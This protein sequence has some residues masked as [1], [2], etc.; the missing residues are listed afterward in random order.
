M[1]QKVDE[2]EHS[3][4]MHIPYIKKMFENHEFK[5]VPIM[6]GSIEADK[7]QEYGKK[8]AKYLDDEKTLFVISSDF[9]HWG[10][11]FDYY[12]YDKEKGEVYQSIE[13]MDRRGM[14]LIEK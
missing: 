12:P 11:N 14:D 7:E 1:N 10:S 6:V 5:L 8:L 4:E 9:C 3:L 2:N 13:A